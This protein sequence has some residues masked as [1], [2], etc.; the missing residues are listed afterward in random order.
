M[1]PETSGAHSIDL[2]RAEKFPGGWRFEANLVAG[3]EA[4]DATLFCTRGSGG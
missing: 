1:V 2:Y 4:S 3:V